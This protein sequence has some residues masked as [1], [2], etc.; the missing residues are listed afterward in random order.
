MTIES[1]SIEGT[2]AASTETNY[3]TTI[4]QSG[5]LTGITT[6]W[7]PPGPEGNL[8]IRLQAINSA[9]V[10]RDLIT[11]PS[12]NYIFGDDGAKSYFTTKRIEKG[13]TLR[14]NT[15]NQDAVSGHDFSVIVNIE[16]DMLPED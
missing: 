7:F 4:R 11:T 5:R 12:N 9:S 1:F 13:E 14:V 2:T 10:I 3:D 6:V 8:R 16:Y 15:N